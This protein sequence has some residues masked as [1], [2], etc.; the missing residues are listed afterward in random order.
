MPHGDIGVS[1]GFYVVIAVWGL[2]LLASLAVA[3]DSLTTR[4]R[5]KV[6]A[7]AELVG[8]TREPLWLYTL[9]SIVL[10][11]MVIISVTP[12]ASMGLSVLV[13]AIALI[14]IGV[15]PL[16]LLRIVFPTA[17]DCDPVVEESEGSEP[18][19]TTASAEEALLAMDSSP[20]EGA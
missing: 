18:P 17:P 7:H 1:A 3:F 15:I 9:P 10:L 13:A 16:Y 5:A 4:R 6:A 2:I 12:F 19:A 20:N 8:F 11:I 14:N